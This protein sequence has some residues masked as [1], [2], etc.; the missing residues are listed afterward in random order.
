MNRS[1]LLTQYS[2]VIP[3]W[4][5]SFPPLFVSVIAENESLLLPPIKISLLKSGVVMFKAWGMFNK[6][7]PDGETKFTS[8]FGMCLDVPW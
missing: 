4:V 8:L 3:I 1:S 7:K 6:V 5:I 2:S